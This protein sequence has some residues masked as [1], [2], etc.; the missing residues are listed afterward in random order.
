MEVVL[1]VYFHKL[2]LFLHYS[3]APARNMAALSWY[4]TMSSVIQPQIRSTAFNA[5]PA[6]WL[7]S[8]CSE[9]TFSQAVF[10]G[11]L[12]TVSKSI[13]KKGIVSLGPPE[14]DCL[15]RVSYFILEFSRRVRE[16]TGFF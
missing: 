5:S 14:S 11:L 12:S 3:N 16:H 7:K 8:C 9:K 10:Q 4:N 6:I 1:I 13:S 15:C 2:Q